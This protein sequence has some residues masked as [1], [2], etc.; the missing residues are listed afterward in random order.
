M[1]IAENYVSTFFI[2]QKIGSCN[3]EVKYSRHSMLSFSLL[4]VVTSAYY[5]SSMK[6]K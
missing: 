6:D 1:D 3:K 4:W 2:L 5:Y